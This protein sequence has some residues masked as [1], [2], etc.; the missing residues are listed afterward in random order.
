MLEGAI[1]AHSAHGRVGG[2]GR[3]GASPKRAEPDGAGRSKPC[4]AEA[5]YVDFIL[6]PR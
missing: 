1:D 4:R 5:D 2:S 6:A 3:G